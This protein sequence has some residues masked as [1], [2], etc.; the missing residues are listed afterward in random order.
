[1]ERIRQLY[2]DSIVTNQAYRLEHNLVRVIADAGSVYTEGPYRQAYLGR[3]LIAMG[4]PVDDPDAY[5][6]AECYL[7]MVWPRDPET[8]LLAGEEMWKDRDMFAG[9]EGRKISLDQ[10]QPLAA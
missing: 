6:M 1:M 2:E 4:Y 9:I 5:Y 10:I 8:G 7:S 3:F